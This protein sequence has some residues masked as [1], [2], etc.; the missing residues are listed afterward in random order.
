MKLLRYKNRFFIFAFY[1]VIS[2]VIVR[3]TLIFTSGSKNK[4]VLDLLYATKNY[5]NSATFSPE[6]IEK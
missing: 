5:E 6:K 1:A 3:T 4:S 2:L